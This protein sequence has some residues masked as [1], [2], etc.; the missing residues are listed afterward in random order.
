MVFKSIFKKETNQTIKRELLNSL[1]ESDDVEGQGF[2][3][4]AND[5]NNSQVGILIIYCHEDIKT[6]NKKAIVYMGK[7]GQLLKRFKYTEHFFDKRI[8]S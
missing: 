8:P 3:E 7:Q 5:V 4:T 1:Q 6:Q 2:N